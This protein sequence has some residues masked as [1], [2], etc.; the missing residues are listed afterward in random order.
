MGTIVV[1]VEIE[2]RADFLRMSQFAITIIAHAFQQI[3]QIARR[4]R[5]LIGKT[6]C[7]FTTDID[8]TQFGKNCF[9]GGCIT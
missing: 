4:I 3:I 8:R 2:M 6:I 5:A 9:E 7:S 1:F